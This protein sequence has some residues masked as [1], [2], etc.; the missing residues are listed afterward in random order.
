MVFG[1]VEQGMGEAG[2]MQPGF[3]LAACRS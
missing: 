2:A 1:M 3:H